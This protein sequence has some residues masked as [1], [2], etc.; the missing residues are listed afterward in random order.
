MATPALLGKIIPEFFLR[1]AVNERQGAELAWIQNL[2]RFPAAYY[3]V[4]QI[5]VNW[6]GRKK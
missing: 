3:H 6:M 1:W 5:L 2:A 4:L